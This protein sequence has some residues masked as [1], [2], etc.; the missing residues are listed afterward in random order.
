MSK[1]WV[2][3][4]KPIG[5][6]EGRYV[7]YC[8]SGWHQGMIKHEYVQICISRNCKN[9]KYLHIPQDNQIKQSQLE[10]KVK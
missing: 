9:L 1:E 7:P 5:R 2:M 3:A 6:G 8:D 10:N 4:Y